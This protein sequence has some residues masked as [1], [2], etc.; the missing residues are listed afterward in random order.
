MISAFLIID[1]GSNAFAA[2]N[3]VYSIHLFS[4][5]GADDARAKTKEFSDLG[6]N[7]FYR[8]ETADGKAD[9][10]NVYI[11]RFKSRSEAEKEANILKELGLISDYDIREIIEKPE[12]IP[13][14]E[15]QK[16]GTTAQAVKSYYLKVGSLR[17]KFNAEDIVKRLQDA[18][19]HAFYNY[20]T[21]K[22]LGDWYRVYIDEYKSK[23]DAEKDAKKLMETGVIS[24]YEIK[25]ATEKIRAA[26][27]K[28]KDEKKIYSLHV[29]S[30]RSSSNADDDVIRLKGLG[31]KAFSIKTEVSGEQWFRVY[32]GEFSEETEARKTGAE[33]TE[34]GVITYFKPLLIDKKGE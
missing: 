11:E 3:A 7:A 14:T 9:V 28:Q 8:Q 6:Y 18:G 31:F 20:E 21:V 15:T 5:K 26:E 25:R 1:I 34:K 33:L 17:E 12:I 27:I 10:Y 32:I 4:F 19:Y 16:T 24:G 22:G 23:A 29:A 30:Y 2:E 13:K